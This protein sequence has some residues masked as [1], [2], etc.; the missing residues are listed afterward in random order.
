[1]LYALEHGD[2]GANKQTNNSIKMSVIFTVGL[3]YHKCIYAQIVLKHILYK[4]YIM[5]IDSQ[6]TP[7]SFDRFEQFKSLSN[8][9]VY[10]FILICLCVI[11]IVSVLLCASYS[12]GFKRQS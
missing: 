11:V 9:H 12:T 7:L 10:V 5:R 2:Y 8:T 6:S 1:M 4:R 3:Y